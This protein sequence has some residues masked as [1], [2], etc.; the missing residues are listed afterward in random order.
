MQDLVFN[1]IGFCLGVMAIC[2]TA[3]TAVFTYQFFVGLL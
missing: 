2:F 1:V 3:V